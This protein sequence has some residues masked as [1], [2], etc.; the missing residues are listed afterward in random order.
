VRKALRGFSPRLA[1]RLAGCLLA[2]ALC[3]WAFTLSPQGYTGISD[4]PLRLGSPLWLC[5]AV[6]LAGLCWLATRPGLARW[7][8]GTALWGLLFGV[9]NYFATT[10][11][12]YDSWQALQGFAAWMGALACMLGQGA[13][14][15][16][17]LAVLC[18][19]LECEPRR[20]IAPLGRGEGSGAAAGDVAPPKTGVRGTWADWLA[21]RF[22]WLAI[23]LY[24]HP[25]LCPM[26]FFLLCWLPFLIAFYPGTVIWDMGEMFGMLQGLRP[27]TTWHPVFL[28]WLFGGCVYLGRALHSDNLGVFLFT[29]LQTLALAYAFAQATRLLR[30]FGLNRGWRVAAMLFFGGV[31]IFGAFA[32]AVGKD[33]LYTAALLLVAVGTVERLR[34]GPASKK[35]LLG[36]AFWAL[37]ACLLRTNGLYV[38][39]GSAVVLVAFGLRGRE[40][41]RV[42]GALGAALAVAFLFQGVLLPALLIQD[43]TASGLYSVCFQQ[44]ARVLRDH[45]DTV[46]AEEWREIDLALDAQKLPALYEP[47]ISDPVKFTFRPY[48]QGRAIET[49]VLARYRRVWLSMLT[50]YPLTYLQAFIA[51]NSGY[52]AFI[53]KI[54]AARTYHLQGGIR[55]VFETVDLGTDPRYLHTTQLPALS[56]ARAFLAL[57]AR[58]WRRVPGL[59]LFL[60]CPVYTWLLI[61]AAHSLARR[62]RWRELTAFMPALLSLGVCLLAPVNDYFRYF[63]PVVAMTVPLLGLAK[64]RQRVSPFGN[65]TRDFI[66]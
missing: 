46:T 23:C 54:D 56:G 64:T 8:V 6:L 2:G 3:M 29:L 42:G 33:T 21:R 20:L 38:V 36:Y 1:V 57:W 55:F 30:R 14:M 50:K 61:A 60:F 39:L 41:L 32:Q 27:M 53:P 12:A 24:R 40:R 51:G 10:L 17:A 34:F 22:P 59:E 7:S 66:P 9:V 37:M 45:A 4:P 49:A 19:W 11:F 35:T 5:Y 25:I 43:E 58:G 63:L 52:Y 15:A 13:A 47:L 48:G 26:A 18:G 28:T 44:S 62:K 16:A 65:L 31:P